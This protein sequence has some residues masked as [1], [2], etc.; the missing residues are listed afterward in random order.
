MEQPKPWPCAKRAAAT[1]SCRLMKEEPLSSLFSRFPPRVGINHISAPSPAGLIISP[2]S[3]RLVM[4]LPQRVRWRI[5][6]DDETLKVTLSFT[7][8]VFT[9]LVCFHSYFISLFLSLPPAVHGQWGATA[10]GRWGKPAV[11][12]KDSGG[13]AVGGLRL[14]M[15]INDNKKKP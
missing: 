12:Q 15:S 14:L 4:R 3:D 10:A 11:E 7:A 6:S 5:I 1:I 8:V 13:D 9:S 2:L